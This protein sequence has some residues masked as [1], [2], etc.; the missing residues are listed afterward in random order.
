[1]IPAVIVAALTA[2]YLGLR[3]GAIAGVATL[4]A[5]VVAGVVPGAM[6]TVYGLI[7]G[8]CALLYFFGQRLAPLLGGKQPRRVAAV[9]TVGRVSQWVRDQLRRVGGA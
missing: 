7:L 3:A 6:I 9:A 5:V 2:W 4:V 8:W 1:V